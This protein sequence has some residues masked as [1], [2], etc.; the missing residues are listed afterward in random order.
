MEQSQRS[1]SACHI[2]SPD[3]DPLF[4]PSRMPTGVKKTANGDQ[5]CRNQYSGS[6][7]LLNTCCPSP[8]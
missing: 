2:P 5:R 3:P 8:G 4:I 7:R 1:N 6:K